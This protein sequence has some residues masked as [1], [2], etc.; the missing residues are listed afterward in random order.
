M[1]GSRESLSDEQPT[2]ETA[3][4]Q[5]AAD[6]GSEGA[7]DDGNEAPQKLELDVKIDNRSACERH[8]T[9]TIARADIDRYLD[10]AFSDMMGTATVPGFRAGRAPRKLIES[11]FRKDVAEQVKGSLLL[12]SL[13]QITEEHE[14]AAISEPDLDPDAVEVPAEGP[15]VFEFDIEVRPEFEMPNWK[16]LSLERPTREFS[17]EDV[18][19]QLQR[20]LER[21]GRLVPTSE[22]A[23]VGDYVTA[24]LT[25]LD[26]DTELATIDERVI[27]VRSVLSFRD[28]RLTGFDKLMKGAKAGD[29]RTGKLKLTDD[30]PNEA[31]RGR[32]ITV[33][34]EVL[35]VKR[36]E[37][38]ELS[39]GLL[40]DLG[41][42]ESE[43]HLR[44]E[45]RQQLERQLSY[46]QQKRT[47]EQVLSMLTKAADWDL[48]PGLLQR[49]SQRE[50]QRAVLELRS[51][52]FSDDQI[53]SYENVLRQNSKA[54]TARALK[55]HFILER[56]AEEESI[57]D[58]PG[59]YDREVTLLALQSGETARR[60]RARLEKQGLMDALR[61]QIIERKTLELVLEHAKYK[62]VPFEFEPADEEAVD[63]AAGGEASEESD[64]T[65]EAAD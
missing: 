6:A 1:A 50:L 27:R 31:L 16:G 49:Q 25:F 62:D 34:F 57:E 40:E 12:D 47:R 45:I 59:D 36:L 17:N 22:P 35:E 38:T 19:N 14:L 7:G 32:E 10:R 39:K 55:E 60:V 33:R 42:F 63:L 23:K 52:G 28:G 26:G 21:R 46:H 24:R 20:I 41:N 51:S 18:E 54:S 56:I 53:R 11:R 43:E 37:A 13:T 15:L 4:A 8:I 30:A 2:D 9:V 3:G 64:S 58:E 48:P 44:G 65:G 61:N 29:I 5:L